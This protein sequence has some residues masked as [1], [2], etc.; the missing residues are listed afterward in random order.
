MFLGMELS[1]SEEE[2]LRKYLPTL[3]KY[4]V[5]FDEEICSLIENCPQNLEC[6]IQAFVGW[7]LSL[8]YRAELEGQDLYLPDANEVLT[9]AFQ[10]EWNSTEFQIERLR[11]AG[12]VSLD[13]LIRNKLSK[14]SFFKTVAYDIPHNSSKVRFF[15]HGEMIWKENIE[16]LLKVSDLNLIEMYKREVNRYREKQQ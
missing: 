4:G 12:L 2:I 9:K 13:L 14:I 3:K 10:W 6:R 5:Y 7:F 11:E 15:H 16:K 1:W 8:E